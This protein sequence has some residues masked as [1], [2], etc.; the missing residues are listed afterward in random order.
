ML[1]ER[2]FKAAEAGELPDEIMEVIR[3]APKYAEGRGV[4]FE[5]KTKKVAAYIRMVARLKMAN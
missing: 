4:R 2:A 1:G 5:L 3:S